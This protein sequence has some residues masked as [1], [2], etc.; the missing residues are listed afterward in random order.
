MIL[1]SFSGTNFQPYTIINDGDTIY[2]RL[3]TSN[4]H[5]CSPDTQQVMFVTIVNPAA[6]FSISNSIGCHPLTVNFTNT[7]SPIS[8]LLSYTWN[9]GNGQ[10]STLQNPVVTF[11][12]TSHTL[13]S[14]Y[15]IRLIVT[16]GTSCVDTIIKTVTVYA[17]PVA[18]FN[19]TAVCLGQN[20]Q[21]TDSSVQA[22][23]PINYYSWNFG[24]GNFNYV[25]NPSHVYASSGLFNVK[26]LITNTKGC[27]DSITKPIIV[28]SLPQVSYHH[29][30]LVCI[31]DTVLFVNTTTGANQYNWNFGNGNF[32]TLFSPSIQYT[33]GGN[34]NIKLI[35]ESV[36]GCIDSSSSTIHVIE[37]PIANFTTIPD[38]GCAPLNVLFTNL[39][40][41]YYVS[42]YWNFGN[43][44]FSTVQN[45]MPVTYPQGQ[46]DTSY[47]PTLTA[48]N[49]CGTNI[50]KDTIKVHPIPVAN[51]N[52]SQ[53]W[54]CTPLVVN[55]SDNNTVGMPDTM[56]WIFGD[57]SLPYITTNTTFQQPIS[58]TYTTGGTVSIYTVTYIAINSCGR[59]TIQKTVTIYPNNVNAFCNAFPDTGCV[60]LIVNFNNSSIGFTNSYWDFGDGTSSNLTSPSHTYTTSGQFLIRLIVNDSC[61]KDTTYTNVSVWPKPVLSFINSKDTLC[62]NEPVSFLNTTTTPLSYFSWDFGDLTTSTQPNPVHFYSSPGTYTVTFSGISAN[63]NCPNTISKQIVVK[64]TP[65]ANIQANPD[66]G[67]TPLTVNFIGDSSFHTWHFGNGNTSG[68]LNPIHTYTSPGSYTIQLIS[69]FANGCSD[70]AYKQITVF[71]KPIA[72]FNKSIDSSCIYPVQV[73]FTNQSI[74]GSGY[75]WG[76]GNGYSS[77][78]NDSIYATYTSPGIYS[79]TLIAHNQYSCTDTIIKSFIVY[80]TPEAYGRLVPTEGCQPLEVLFI[81]SSFNANTYKW[82]FG[83][84]NMSTIA[85]PN[86]TYLSYGSFAVTL[87]IEGSGGCRDT[88]NLTDTITVFPKPIADFVYLQLDTP[89][90]PSGYVQF[91]N[92]SL[93]S[94]YYLWDFGDL[95]SDTSENPWHRYQM[96]GSYQVTLYAENIF[97]C[98]DTVYDELE[99]DMFHALYIPNAFSPGYGPSE[100]QVF[101]PA[102][103]GIVEYHIWIYDTWGNLIWES[104]KL[105]NSEPEESW[106]GNDRYGNPLMQDV[107]VWKAEA[108]FND[109]TNWP[110]EKYKVGNLTKRR[111][112]G[113]VTLLR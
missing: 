58:H 37:P 44:Q 51:I 9:F 7:S 30:T 40:I 27:S 98:K 8:S 68:L 52:L 33:S 84:G 19:Y 55:F 11:T 59:D 83:D 16:A 5:G 15:V 79:D 41:G 111:K 36:F 70:T 97:G 22:T 104:D 88:L 63:F 96:W 18:N 62:T 112:Y 107:Y 38:T 82:F 24:D 89:V 31:N 14:T 105:I 45:P 78:V 69:E 47:Y 26:H 10:T 87:I 57:G 32:S 99:I 101:K 71:P 80:P 91:T 35:A 53:Y 43:G 39:S 72:D 65:T 85:N 48:A 67:C 90:N 12:N 77:N 46:N 25:Q 113:T 93:L 28:Y 61:G 76:F 86:Y 81:D 6:D 3:I 94:N 95:L 109:G 100:V 1:G 64:P 102:G 75:Y 110:G 4:I 42:Y 21:F 73:L 2:V 56:I 50:H 92:L 103:V 54:G 13:D 29:D 20:T 34:F 60:P 74:G 17:L 23:A 106:D 49:V 108:K 66:N